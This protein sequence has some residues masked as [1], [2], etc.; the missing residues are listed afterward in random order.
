MKLERLIIKKTKSTTSIIR[1]VEFKKG[2]N[3]IIDDTKGK[4]QSTGNNIGKTT[5]IK[6]IDLCLGGKSIKTLYFDSD[7]NSI[8]EEVKKFLEDNKVV[9]ELTLENG[10][11]RLTIEKDLFS[12][13]KWRI[14]GE[15]YSQNNLWTFLKIKL[16]GSNEKK[17]TLRNLIPKFIRISDLTSERMLKYLPDMTKTSDYDAIYTFLFKLKNDSIISKVNELTNDLKAI[18]KKINLL[19]KDRN[20]KSLSSLEQRKELIDVELS[21]YEEKKKKI[22][23][24]KTNKV[25]IEKMRNLIIQIDSIE[26]EIEILDLEIGLIKENIESLEKEGT[27]INLSVLKEIYNEAEGYVGKLQKR[28]EEMVTFHNTM[29]ENRR[30]YISNDLNIKEK[31][32]NNLIVKRNSLLKEK[33]EIEKMIFVEDTLDEIF[34]ASRKYEELLV[35]KGQVTNGINI[36]SDINQEKNE[37]SL[38]LN[39]IKNKDNE[40]DSKEI[41]KCF[42]MIFS[43]YSQRLYNEKYF[44]SY[45]ENWEESKIFP[46]TCETLSGQIG[47][48]KKKAVTI[49]FDLAYLEFSNI[50]NI[51][52]PK[53][54]IHDKLENTYINQLETIFKISE[55]I[56]GQ[57]IV[58]ILRERV[59]KLDEKLIETCKVIELSEEDKLF[60]I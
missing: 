5:L 14:D 49:A 25:E 55:S 10:N 1:N 58:P 32:N 9:A 13:G 60:R 37:I 3:L 46:I 41:I 27:N 28:F 22:N 40:N 52:C 20:L 4:L 47:T 15:E 19:E 54:V 29:L 45:N 50:R 17:P 11:E 34:A 57:L 8:N 36:L 31:E 53:F 35:E 44:I 59:S 18:D 6:I 7:T 51:I 30:E 38:K 24:L 39:T 2:L 48:G 26:A 43:E 21:K 23:F 16:F 42:N 12:R 33:D 56:Q